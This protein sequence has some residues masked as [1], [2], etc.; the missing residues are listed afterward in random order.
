VNPPSFLLP[1]ED[2]RQPV[3]MT[4]LDYYLGDWNL[5]LHAK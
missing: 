1:A 3:A 4:K 5:N 2:L